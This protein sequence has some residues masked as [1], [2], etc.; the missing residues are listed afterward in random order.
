[1]LFLVLFRRTCLGKAI[2]MVA[3]DEWWLER[4]R[5]RIKL[6]ERVVCRWVGVSML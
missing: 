2:V 3:S 1:V 6:Q 5:S 4:G